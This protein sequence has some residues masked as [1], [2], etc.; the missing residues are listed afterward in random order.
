MTTRVGK[1][2]ALASAALLLFVVAVSTSVDAAKNATVTARV[3]ED[4][5]YLASDELEGRGPNSEGLE[6]AAQYIRAEFKRLG[7]KS[8]T[9]D[10]SYFQ[11]FEIPL[12]IE[13]VKAKTTLVFAE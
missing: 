7:L 3:S 2:A 8:C 11:P 10:G 6:K 5:R 1:L 4:I 12:K 9:E 13:A